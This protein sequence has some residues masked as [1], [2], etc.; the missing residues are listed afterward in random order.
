MRKILIAL[1]FV[2]IAAILS[3][4]VMAIGPWQATESND[5]HFLRLVGDS[6]VNVRGYGPMG[7]NAWYMDNA[8]NWREWRF[9]EVRGDE[10]LMNS[11][12]VCH[13]NDVNPGFLG[14]E[15]NQNTWIYLS[16]DANGQP[17]QMNGHGTLY[18]FMLSLFG[19]AFAN[20]MASVEFPNGAFY[21]YNIID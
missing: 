10:G 9:R 18:Y 19:Q 17:N 3:T 6:V 4:P 13:L 21:M 5:N 20:Q 2:M 14:G 15:E 1:V 7:F 16:G 8:G 12:I 11:A